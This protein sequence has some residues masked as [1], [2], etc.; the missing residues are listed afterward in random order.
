M[1]LPVSISTGGVSPDTCTPV[2]PLPQIALP[3]I[4]DALTPPPLYKLKVRP[5][6]KFRLIVLFTKPTKACPPIVKPPLP[7]LCTWLFD[8]STMRDPG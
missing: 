4:P 3:V 6:P 7:L 8:N 5:I 2:S 1:S